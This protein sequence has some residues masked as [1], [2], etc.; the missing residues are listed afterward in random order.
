[1][2]II[3]PPTAHDQ[4]LRRI[5]CC[6]L[7]V[8]PVLIYKINVITSSVSAYTSFHQ[9]LLALEFSVFLF[10]HVSLQEWRPLTQEDVIIYG[11][12]SIAINAMHHIYLK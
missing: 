3:V 6:V 1:M 7:I 11:R 12:I 2:C 9:L 4:D 5:S 8:F 10:K